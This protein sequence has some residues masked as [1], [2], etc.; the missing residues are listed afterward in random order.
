MLVK[1]QRRSAPERWA[2][3]HERC[4]IVT[5]VQQAVDQAATLWF[6]LPI[7][8]TVCRITELSLESTPCGDNAG[9]AAPG[10]CRHEK[11]VVDVAGDPA[12][13]R[14]SPSDGLG[15]GR[16]AFFDQPTMLTLL[17]WSMVAS[18]P[19]TVARQSSQFY[20][21]LTPGL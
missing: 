2:V 16:I 15:A 4:R 17:S 7:W 1:R 10:V 19:A 18:T 5:A 9:D 20:C 12:P 21:R 14:R 11:V 13:V 6:C 8:S 3:G